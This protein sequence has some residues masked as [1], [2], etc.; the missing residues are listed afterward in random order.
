MHIVPV[1]QAL[2]TE[3]VKSTDVWS[4]VTPAAP[5]GVVMFGS[6]SADDP[7]GHVVIAAGARSVLNAAD[8]VATL[9]DD[10]HR[11]ALFPGLR[12]PFR[13]SFALQF[14]GP[15][16]LRL[17]CWSAAGYSSVGTM[18]KPPHPEFPTDIHLVQVPTRVEPLTRSRFDLMLLAQLSDFGSL[19]ERDAADAS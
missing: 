7:L 10:P 12:L 16:T 15:S 8:W 4:V 14:A 1:H 6:P 11:M 5:S 18:V 2:L 9:L 13:H 17:A 3:L 19:I